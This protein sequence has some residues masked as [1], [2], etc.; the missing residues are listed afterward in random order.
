MSAAFERKEWNASAIN[1]IHCAVSAADA[2]CIYKLGQRHAGQRHG[3]AISLFLS[4]N[5]SDSDLKKNAQRLSK[6][7]ACKT[8]SEYGERL[9]SRKDAEFLK[10]EVERLLNFVKT[11]LP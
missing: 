7:I 5:P 3:D 11:M 2:V 9:V 4:V 10:K 8:D 1:A 6:I